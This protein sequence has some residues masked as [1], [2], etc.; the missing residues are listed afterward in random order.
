MGSNCS[1]TTE[2]TSEQQDPIQRE[3]IRPNGS[4]HVSEKTNIFHITN[5]GATHGNSQGWMRRS[6]MLKRTWGLWLLVDTRLEVYCVFA[7]FTDLTRI[8]KETL[9]LFFFHF[10]SACLHERLTAGMESSSHGSSTGLEH[11]DMNEVIESKIPV[12]VWLNR[13]AN[14]LALTITVNQTWK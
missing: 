7:H 13:S 9:S 12:H 3:K 8:P 5:D 6:R 4:N 14:S 1:E 10:L 11:L 2:H